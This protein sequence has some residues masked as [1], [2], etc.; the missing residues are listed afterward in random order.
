MPRAVFL[1]V[2]HVYIRTYGTM[3]LCVLKKILLKFQQEGVLFHYH[4]P[5]QYRKRSNNRDDFLLL[6]EEYVESRVLFFQIS[7]GSKRL[8]SVLDQNGTQNVGARVVPSAR[9]QHRELR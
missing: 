8:G 4:V 7:A 2:L 9:S 1:N 5:C 3:Y 6:E